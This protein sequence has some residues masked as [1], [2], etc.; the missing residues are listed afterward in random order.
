NIFFFPP[1]DGLRDA[2]VTGV[3]TCPLP[4]SLPRTSRATLAK[5]GEVPL[6]P[7]IRRPPRAE[8]RERYQTVYA[9]HDGSVAAPTAGLHFTSERTEERRGGK[10]S[11]T[12]G[13]RGAEQHDEGSR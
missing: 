13:R 7:Y 5:Y 6:P 9:V 1:D 8:D 10:E 11:S 4:I 12:G 3:Q 2:H